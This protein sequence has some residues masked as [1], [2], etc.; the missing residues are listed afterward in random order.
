MKKISFA[1]GMSFALY[2][3]V[4]G[5][6]D[7]VFNTSRREAEVTSS[8]SAGLTG[9]FDSRAFDFEGSVSGALDSRWGESEASA[10]QALDTTKIGFS[11]IIR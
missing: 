6:D 7:W 8:A 3:A 2:G 9:V 4:A 10:P 5:V 11:I 1:L